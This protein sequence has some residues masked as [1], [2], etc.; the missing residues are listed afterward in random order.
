M[1]RNG[2]VLSRKLVILV[3]AAV[4][5][6]AAGAFPEPAALA[7]KSPGIQQVPFA[8][9]RDKNGVSDDLDA[10]IRASAGGTEPIPVVVVLADTP[11]EETLNALRN[12]TGHFYPDTVWTQ[13]IRGFAAKLRPYQIEAMAR[14]PGVVRVDLDRPVQASMNTATYWTGVQKI[15][16]DWGVDGDHD[17]DPTMGDILDIVVCVLDTGIDP[18]HRDLD[19]HKVIGWKDLVNGG[20]IPYDDN[21]HGTHVAGIIA[22]TGQG[23]PAYKGV[24][25]GAALVGVK[26]L[27]YAGTGTASGV[28]SGINWMIANK[29]AYNIRVGNMSLGAEGS[30]DGTD[31]VS[32]AVNNAVAAGIVMCVSA[33]NSG[34]SRYTIGSPAAAAQAIT[35]GAVY[36]P[37]ELGWTIA[38]F[39]SRGPTA[40]DRTKPDVCIPGVAI[41]SCKAGTS[42]GYVAMS[43][44]SMACAFMSGVVALLLDANDTLTPAQVK[45]ILASN[46]KDF[47]PPGQDNDYGYG[48]LKPYDAVRQA[49]GYTGTWSDGLSATYWSGYCSESLDYYFKVYDTSKPIAIGMI[50]PEWESALPLV[51]SIDP[52]EETQALPSELP[53]PEPARDLNTTLYDPLGQLVAESYGT[54]RQET[55]RV[56]PPRVGIYR[57]CVWPELGS[58]AHFWLNI[59]WK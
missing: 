53:P 31:S 37:G 10:T 58:E 24:A 51:K 36:D 59:S 2:A 16:S 45:A 41:M 38:P 13:A 50:I 29:S 26:V 18:L 22:G 32:L 30:S 8:G 9:D 46:V 52:T 19:E 42:S 47:G 35:V 17:G 7:A 39:S 48:I 3:L 54:A 40:D 20:T 1:A 33:G 49:G 6:A 14:C 55:I 34:P 5:A 25:P 28:I 43:G 4:L 57:L 11:S 23:N 44:T 12:R 27:D 15:W 21:G 56:M